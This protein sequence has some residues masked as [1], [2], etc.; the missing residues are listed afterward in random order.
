M[1][2]AMVA[3]GKLVRLAPDGKVDREIQLPVTNP[4]C[5]AFGGQKLDQ[6]FVTSHS[7]RIPSEQMAREPYAGGL[8]MLDVGVKGVLEPRFAG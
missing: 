3:T 4:T 5:P 6:L 8:F 2:N 1:W 7:Q